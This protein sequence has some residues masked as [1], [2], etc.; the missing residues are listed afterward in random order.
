MDAAAVRT[1]LLVV[2]ILMALMAFSYL[3]SRKLTWREYIGLGLVALLVPLLGPFL[4][5]LSRPGEPGS[6]R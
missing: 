5:I 1:L 2:I 3:R 6:Q 4:V